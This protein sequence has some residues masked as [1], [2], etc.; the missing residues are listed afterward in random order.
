MAVGL[1]QRFHS[2]T[3]PVTMTEFSR[4]LQLGMPLVGAQLAQISINTMDVLM[5]SWL[6]PEDLGASVLAFNVYVVLWLTG[7]GIVQA[8]A[9]LSAQAYGAGKLKVMRRF[10]RHAFW[11]ALIYSLFSMILLEYIGPILSFLGQERELVIRAEIYMDALKWAFLPGLMTVGL[12]VFLATT[13]Y[14]GAFLWATIIMAFVNGILNYGLIFG[15]LGMPRLELVGAGIASAVS[16]TT[17]LLLIVFYI[18]LHKKLRLFKLFG[19]IWRVELQSFKR[20][21]LL[22]IPIGMALLSEVGMFGFASIMM[23]WIGVQELA[24]HAIVLQC[25]TVAF[26]IPLG[27]G[28]A[29]VIRVGIAAGR[30]DARGVGIAGWTAVVTGMAVMCVS[31]TIFWLF[32]EFLISLYQDEPN[33]LT[34]QVLAIGVTF[35]FIAALF[36]LVDGTQVIGQC[37]LRGLNDTKVPMVYAILGYWVVGLGSGYIFAFHFQ[38]N[39]IGIWWG[40]ALGLTVV[41]IALTIRFYRREKLGLVNRF[42][43]LGNS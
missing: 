15:N 6:S 7:L 28:Q 10:I 36:Q 22:G 14:T 1:N 4:L 29:A 23:G 8:S 38:L 37:A 31:A 35:M 42:V 16:A 13:G 30:G 40:L 32:P 43:D 18:Q 27:I 33:Q 20:I 24:A 3:I 2:R 9:P 5:I 34:E 21:I 12:R 25:A 19:N 11:I 26:M 41:A 17:A 39:G